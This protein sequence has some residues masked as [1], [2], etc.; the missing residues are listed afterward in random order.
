VVD[1]GSC[2]FVWQVIPSIVQYYKGGYHKKFRV[3]WSLSVLNVYLL[4]FVLAGYFLCFCRFLPD[5]H[6][7]FLR[8]YLKNSNV[9]PK[10]AIVLRSEVPQHMGDPVAFQSAILSSFWM[11]IGFFKYGIFMSRGHTGHSGACFHKQF[12]QNFCF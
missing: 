11:V 10:F 9:V 3:N 6:S 5:L 2:N 8:N 1:C 4:C 12:R 7:M